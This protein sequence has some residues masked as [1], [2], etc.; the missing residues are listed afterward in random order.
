M[1]LAIFHCILFIAIK[2]IFAYYPLVFDVEQS[3]DPTH[4]PFSSPPKIVCVCGSRTFFY[5]PWEF[6]SCALA[7]VNGKKLQNFRC[8][9]K[10]STF[11]ECC[12]FFPLFRP[13]P[14]HLV[15]TP[16]TAIENCA[17][18]VNAE[19]WGHKSFHFPFSFHIKLDNSFEIRS[20]QKTPRPRTFS[21]KDEAD[22][23]F[24]F[25]PVF[26]SIARREKRIPI[27]FWKGILN[28]CIATCRYMEEEIKCEEAF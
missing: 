18:P 4:K 16:S 1:I 3:T 24:S 17:S 13:S 6:L 2:I 9:E 19:L 23:K 28:L 5:N 10:F 20:P 8:E 27:W 15:P 22:W 14:Q 12:C 7:E 11:N 25:S 26:L 21:E